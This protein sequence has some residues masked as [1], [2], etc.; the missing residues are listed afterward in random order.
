ME[1]TWFKES[2]YAWIGL[3]SLWVI[4]FIG[5]LTR[6]SL[7]FFQVQIS[8]DLQISRGFISMAWSTNLFIVAVCAPLGAGSWIVMAQRRY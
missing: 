4:G 7:S 1:T 5:A 6:F 3:G 2:R 8:T